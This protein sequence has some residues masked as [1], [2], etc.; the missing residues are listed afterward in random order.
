MPKYFEYHLEKAPH[1]QDGAYFTGCAFALMQ[2]VASCFF[3]KH[4]FGFPFSWQ[5]IDGYA[6]VGFIIGFHADAF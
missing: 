6:F 3:G 1:I 5:T 2:V 4:L